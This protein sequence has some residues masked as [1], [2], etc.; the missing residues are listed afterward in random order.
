MLEISS[1]KRGESRAH[2]RQVSQL[3]QLGF[4]EHE[5]KAYIALLGSSP[6]TAYDV[7]KRSGLPRPNA[8]AAVESLV[9][10]G[11]LQPVS[12]KPVRYVPI[13]P[14]ELL[15]RIATETT[16]RCREL[17]GELTSLRPADG[18]DY[19]WVVKGQAAIDELIQDMIEEARQHIWIKA[20]AKLIEPYRERLREASERGVEVLLILF[21]DDEAA[22]PFRFPG[23]TVYLH[24]ATGIVIA[25]GSHM[26]TL[27][28]DY[29][30][31]L[32]VNT[33]DGGYGGHTRSWPIVQLADSLVRH[34]VYLAE[35]FERFGPELARAFGPA[36]LSLR[37]KYIPANQIDGLKA[38]LGI[39]PSQRGVTS[40]GE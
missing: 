32:V 22:R 38:R 1:G 16:T 35:I 34:E 21:G 31:A 7:S 23:A 13:D 37:Q 14:G 19:V 10:K 4:T 25:L 9:K 24:E 6:A 29:E 12:R 30:N 17:A 28:T 11:A 20:S 26:I 2:A 36:L 18:T 5:A 3:Q 39:A 27:T 8:Y 33:A 15:G 40:S